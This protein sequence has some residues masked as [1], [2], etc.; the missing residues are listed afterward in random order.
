MID[1]LVE[2]AFSTAVPPYSYRKLGRGVNA[3]LADSLLRHRHWLL[4]VEN[5][6]AS[7]AVLAYR[8]ALESIEAS[9]ARVALKDAG[10][11]SNLA[12]MRRDRL[13]DLAVRIEEAIQ[14]G[15]AAAETNVACLMRFMTRS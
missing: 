6:V 11:M 3:R 5:R 2:A 1:P 13:R 10:A 8:E 12:L 9:L 14:I 4:M 15:G 7:S